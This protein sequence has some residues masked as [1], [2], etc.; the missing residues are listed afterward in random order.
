MKK[1]YKL[2]LIF[3][4]LIVFLGAYF[5]YKMMVFPPEVDSARIDRADVSNEAV[6]GKFGNNWIMRN[7]HGLWE[8]YLEGDP[9]ERG[10][11]FG[12]LTKTLLEDK[13]RVF[14]REIQRRIPSPVYFNFLKFVVGWHNRDLE[15][16]IPNEYALEIYGAS[17]F[18]SDAYDF[19][20]PK[21]HRSLNYHA[22]HDIGHAMQNL[23]LVGCTSFAFRKEGNP[24][25]EELIIGRNFDFYFG[26]EFAKDKILAFIKPDS[27][28]NFVSVT[29]A[30]FSGVVSGMN[31]QGLTVTLNSAKTGISFKAKTPVSIIGRHILQYAS[32]I[33]E[34]YRIAETYDS[35]VA[36]TFLIGSA[37]DGKAALIEKSQNKT[38]L[39]QSEENRLVVTNH[40]QSEE[41]KNDKNNLEYLDEGVSQYRFNR[42]EELLQ[43]YGSITPE[44]AA[45]ILRNQ[46]GLDSNNIGLGNEKAINQLI[47]HH[48]V[49]FSPN[50][51]LVWVSTAPYQLGKYLCYDLNKVF[52]HDG[53]AQIE[54]GIYIDS[55]SIAS[56][57]FLFSE[58]YADYMEYMHISEK[59]RSIV[60]YGEEDILTDEESFRYL[61][62]N[63]NN[64]LTYY[65]LGEYYLFTRNYSKAKEFLK[66]GL[67]KEIA[68]KSERKHMEDGLLT[69]EKK[70]NK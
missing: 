18:M 47:A 49:I 11:A 51:L 62:T 57:Q 69:C 56:D 33:E 17:L 15:N 36:E 5:V 59:I 58:E 25:H 65:Y 35:F 70:L 48:S 3:L 54:G 7:N 64:Y 38:A 23:N 32:T 50:S 60:Y 67:S 24:G 4:G 55:L 66:I 13:E 29:W 68:R 53:S 6:S 37:R 45:G 2:F 21:Y 43:V 12:K 44:L 8:L 20:A 27:G 63:P 9:L 22:A 39:F 10:L 52:T 41:L 28:Y 14:V 16:Y 46:S 34:A 30:G 1:R 19:I 40:F 31:D 61:A 26:E 42:V